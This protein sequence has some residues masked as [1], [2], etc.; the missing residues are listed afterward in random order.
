[1]EWNPLVFQ[2]S[3]WYFNCLEWD[4]RLWWLW[5][6]LEWPALCP[7]LFVVR[8]T[9]W[10]AMLLSTAL[11][12]PQP[13]R[14]YHD[15]SSIPGVTLWMFACLGNHGYQ[16]THPCRL[17]AN[18]IMFEKCIITMKAVGTTWSLGV[19]LQD[20]FCRFLDSYN[21]HKRLAIGL[22][23]V[24]KNKHHYCF[25]KPTKFSSSSKLIPSEIE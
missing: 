18:K 20:V 19:M 6:L 4:M 7:E 8:W 22:P 3:S 12:L 9:V 1:M 16:M 17:A 11:C 13:W 25:L 2:A 14:V 5:V 10:W 21:Y 15:L 24:L 23:Y